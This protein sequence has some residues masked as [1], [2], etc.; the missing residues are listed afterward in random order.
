MVKYNK[1]LFLYILIL[2]AYLPYVSM[3]TDICLHVLSNIL[4]SSALGFVL[5]S[6]QL[7]HLLSN[8]KFNVSKTEHVLF[9]SK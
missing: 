4:P 5:K 8:T 1:L 3:W 7:S 9:P 6:M 2:S